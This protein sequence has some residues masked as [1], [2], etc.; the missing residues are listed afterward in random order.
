MAV[1]LIEVRI[2]DS[3]SD[4]IALLNT[5]IV[6]VFTLTATVY[7]TTP[8]SPSTPDWAIVGSDLYT[9]EVL[10]LS[11]YRRSDGRVVVKYELDTSA[12][13]GVTAGYFYG[14]SININASEDAAVPDEV[15]DRIFKI[16]PAYETTSRMTAE[17]PGT[18]F[19]GATGIQG[20]TGE[21]GVGPR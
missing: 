17:V 13:T 16:L 21:T 1:K 19:S 14:V 7:R 10:A 11:Y 20:E 8:P 12:I 6:E 4:E 2:N 18:S 15:V 9:A 3:Q 5:N